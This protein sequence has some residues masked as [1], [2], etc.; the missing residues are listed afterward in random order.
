MVKR[1]LTIRARRGAAL[2]LALFVM[3]VTSA[4]VIAVMDTQQLQYATLRH[5]VDYDQARYLAECGIQHALS[6]LENDITWRTGISSTEFPP[7][8]G[9]HYSA[10][11]TDGAGGLVIIAA[12]GQAGSFTRRLQVT[13]KQGG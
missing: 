1:Q 10:T 12:E 4:L 5:T 3:V 13:L 6:A 8:S 7:G 2:L 9:N 11:V